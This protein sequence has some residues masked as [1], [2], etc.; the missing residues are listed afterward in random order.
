MLT[1]QGGPSVRL[2]AWTPELVRER[3]PAVQVRIGDRV[4]AAWTS[5]RAM[6]CASVTAKLPIE[7]TGASVPVTFEF[8]WDALA[9]VLNTGGQLKV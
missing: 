9:R 6:P 2:P 5:G 1:G 8:S 3:L 7:G 4:F